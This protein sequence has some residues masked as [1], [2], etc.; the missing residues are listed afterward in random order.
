MFVTVLSFTIISNHLLTAFKK[1]ATNTVGITSVNKDT[2]RLIQRTVKQ[3]NEDSFFNKEGITT[4][5]FLYTEDYT[6]RTAFPNYNDEYTVSIK[7]VDVKEDLIYSKALEYHANGLCYTIP[8]TNIPTSSQL[9][10]ALQNT[11]LIAKDL[12]YA[13]CPI[14]LEGVLIGYIGSVP[15]NQSQSIYTTTNILKNLARNIS[16]DL[17]TKINF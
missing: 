10:P 14:Y 15:S 9:Y 4:T 11:N 6:K 2:I 12:F 8:T 1:V 7:E 5:L 17:T 3:N 13:S 16:N